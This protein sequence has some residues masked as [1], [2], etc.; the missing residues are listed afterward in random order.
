MLCP[1]TL[2]SKKTERNSLN[3]GQQKVKI[4]KATDACGLLKML[5]KSRLLSGEGW[6]VQRTT[7]ATEPTGFD[8]LMKSSKNKVCKSKNLL[9][10]VYANIALWTQWKP[11]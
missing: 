6:G 3:S 5:K 4:Y 7:E 11:D 2:W 9:S 10:A 8:K 1:L